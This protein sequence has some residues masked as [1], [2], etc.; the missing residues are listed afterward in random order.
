MKKPIIFLIAI[1][2]CITSI[3]SA[4]NIIDLTNTTPIPTSTTKTTIKSTPVPTPTIIFERYSE[5]FYGEITYMDGSPV[6][7]GNTIIAKDQYGNLLGNYTIGDD[8]I[9]GAT[10]P[11]DSN[12]IVSVYKD[13]TNRTSR[14]ALIF[15]NFF[16]GNDRMKNTIEFKSGEITKFNII[17]PVL[18]PTP[19]PTYTPTPLPTITTIATTIAPTTIPTPIPTQP[20]IVDKLFGPSE[21]DNI[22]L[23]YGLLM[24]GLIVTGILI[25]GIVQSY[26][27]SKSSRDDVLGP[28][29]LNK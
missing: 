10:K 24:G 7:A 21:S 16:I 13:P 15:V 2:F 12:M 20:S 22:Y 18:A 14:D 27:M 4:A 26:L 6:K 19:I 9:Y 11:R 28:E 5:E 23:F 25:V 8:G 29:D 3:V 1:V 17:I